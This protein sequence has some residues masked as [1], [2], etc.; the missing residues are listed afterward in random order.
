MFEDFSDKGSAESKKRLGTS[1]V[2]SAA[3]Y[4]TIGGALVA[5]TAAARTVI[6]EELSQVQ[7]AP[8]PRIEAP[9]PAPVAPPPA[10][11]IAARRAGAPRGSAS[12]RAPT[13]I[14]NE[15][16]AESD[17]PLGPD[18]GIG[19]PDGLGERGNIP[20]TPVAPAPVETVRAPS[21]VQVPERATMPSPLSGNMPVAYPEEARLQGLRATVVAKI[22]IKTD[23]TVGEIQILR[24][25]PMFDE[26]V[27]NT[28]RSWR[29]TPA[30]LDG[31]AI[32]VF[33]TVPVRFQLEQ[34]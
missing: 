6:Q 17:G 19:D 26:V 16:L 4:M 8:P 12:L 27:K 25:H 3:L 22:V 28:I 23:G 29:F 31:E 2:V 24:G 10:A 14:S 7:F 34:L 15:R 11:K 21:P 30:M 5:A 20:P 33:K 9:P 32:E 1:M 18:L 13:T